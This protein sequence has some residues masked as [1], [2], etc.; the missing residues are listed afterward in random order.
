ML[1][2]RKIIKLLHVYMRYDI[3]LWLMGI[4]TNW[5][6]DNRITIRFR[7]LLYKP[8]IYKCGKNFTVAKWVQLKSTHNLIIGDN[9]YFAS[10][11]WMNAMGGLTVENEVVLGPYVVISTGNH[12]FRDNSVR[13]GGTIM[14][15]V[16]IGRGSWLAAHVIVRAGITIGSGVLVAGNASVSKD[17][18]DN[19]IVGGV[20]AKIISERKDTDEEVKYSRF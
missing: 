13:F 17:V 20:P 5:L 2:V 11:V 1:P 18:P 12:A 15:P 6:P 8:F 9:V 16:R 10:G 4:L 3:P 7:G 19:V 14:E